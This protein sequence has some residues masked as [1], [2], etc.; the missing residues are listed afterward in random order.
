RS[1]D[2]FR[3]ANFAGTSPLG[4]VLAL[5]GDDHGAVSSTTA[6]Q[7]EYNFQSLGMP[8]LHPATVQEYLDFG[9]LGLAM[10]RFA[11]LWVGFK[12]VTETAESTA[13]VDLDRHALQIESPKDFLFPPDGPHIRWPDAMLAQ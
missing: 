12:C 4:G 1:L 5:A 3:H 11:G 10:S 7:S 9:L 2:A 13:S 6:H 8:F